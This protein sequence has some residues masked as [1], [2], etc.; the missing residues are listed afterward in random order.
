[1]SLNKNEKI[2]VFLAVIL[3]LLFFLF[4]GNFFDGNSSDISSNTPPEQDSD[5]NPAALSELITEDV[6]LG[7]GAEAVP[8]SLVT[9]HYNGFLTDGT[10][11]DSSVD[12]GEPFQFLLGS[13]QVIKG[14]DQGVS[15]MKIGGVRRL[16]IPPNLGYGSKQ[17]GQIPPGSTLLFEIEL[18]EVQNQEQP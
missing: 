16:S 3:A 18:L 8:G 12:R 17:A 15:G 13:G 10:K 4:T 5:Q 1:M 6:I 11:F 9:V 7:D 14:W 2:G